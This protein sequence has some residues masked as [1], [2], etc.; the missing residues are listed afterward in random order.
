MRTLS[1]NRGTY[2]K[3]RMPHETVTDVA[4]DATIRAA[5][6]QGRACPEEGRIMKIKKQDIREKLR[7][8]KISTPTVFV[9]D[10]SGSMYANERMESAKGAV[11]S[12]L[13]HAYQKRDKVGLVA[14]REHRAEVVLPLCSSLDY[15]IEC[16]KDLSSG[17]PTPLSAGLQKGLEL[18]VRE[19]RKSPDV[20]PVLVLISDGRANV[21]LAAGSEITEELL[22]L[23]AVAWKNKIH[24]V[25]ID[26]ELAH[27]ASQRH[28]NN[29][30]IL[31]DRMSYYHVEYLTSYAVQE[32]VSAEKAMLAGRPG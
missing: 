14:F 24:M 30:Q 7:S 13:V 26:V 11:F 2:V 18:L 19:K 22:E 27:S 6:Q 16:L 12:L 10:A 29:K 3:A 25:F 9:V 23:T 1:V 8:S 31:Q 20:I 32:I 15:A 4:L 21:P 17:G 5:C 28:A